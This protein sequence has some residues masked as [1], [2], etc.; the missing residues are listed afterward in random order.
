MA[1]AHAKGRDGDN[2]PVA[3]ALA[4]EGLSADLSYAN[5]A[6][7]TIEVRGAELFA[8]SEGVLDTSDITRLHA[9]RVATRRLRAV[10][11]FYA[12]CLPKEQLRPTLKRVR[13]LADALGDRREPDVELAALAQFAQTASPADRP[14]V[15]RFI[16]VTRRRQEEANADL[17]VALE[18]MEA[19]DL[20]G[21][22]EEL[23]A[24]AA[25]RAGIED[26][27]LESEWGTSS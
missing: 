8:H 21:R 23:A 20:R 19:D 18:E 2:G 17:A 7:L 13:R 22:L 3:K 25:I 9:M 24:A 26:Q 15:E 16:E 6:A 5:A 14:G 11:E 10:L 4:I 12:P 1:S 27:G